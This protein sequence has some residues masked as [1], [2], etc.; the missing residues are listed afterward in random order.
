MVFNRFDNYSLIPRFRPSYFIS[1][2][3]FL[4]LFYNWFSGK[5]RFWLLFW[6]F[7]WALYCHRRTWSLWFYVTFDFRAYCSFWGLSINTIFIFHSLINRPLVSL[8]LF[9]NFLLNLTIATPTNRPVTIFLP[10]RRINLHSD[11]TF[12]ALN[13]LRIV[14][15]LYGNGNIFQYLLR[16][17]SFSSYCYWIRDFG[18]GWLMACGFFGGE[19]LGY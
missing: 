17:G 14:H 18:S 4:L 1:W 12:G 15:K 5:N 16:I 7:L 13:K 8:P 10:D 9:P 2:F 11:P 6:I 19:L 3:L